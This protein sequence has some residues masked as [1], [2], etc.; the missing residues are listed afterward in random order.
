[1]KRFLILWCA[2]LMFASCTDLDLED[3]T[4]KLIELPG[5]VAFANT[6]GTITPIERTVA[7]TST[8]VQNLRIEVAT[9]TL[10]DVT[11]TYSFS[12]NAAFG[13]DFTVT[14]PGGTATAAGG[15]IVIK[16]N[17]TPAGTTDFDFVNLGIHAVADG[18]DDGDKSLTITLESAANAD[19]KTFAVGRGAPGSTIYLKSA[20]VIFTDV[21]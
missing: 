17:Q 2:G 12:G 5:Y 11:V 3:Q 10:S 15:T 20:R 6:G 7:E 16:R 13:T 1:M 21:D 8:A 19:G 4:I 14:T 9:G 18:V